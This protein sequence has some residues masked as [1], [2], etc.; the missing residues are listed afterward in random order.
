MLSKEIEYARS[1]KTFRTRDKEDKKNNFWVVK[2][3]KYGGYNFCFFVKI[4]PGTQQ[5]FVFLF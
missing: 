4:F 3:T 5:Q 1:L 2:L